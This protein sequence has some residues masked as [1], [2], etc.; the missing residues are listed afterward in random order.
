MTKKQRKIDFKKPDFKKRFENIL[1][2]RIEKGFKLNI[3]TTDYVDDEGDNV[4]EVHATASRWGLAKML[5]ITGMQEF[6]TCGIAI[7]VAAQMIQHFKT[8][9]KEEEQKNANA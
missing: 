2:T 3:N 8:K 5:F 1:D 6:E 4:M 7:C 9:L